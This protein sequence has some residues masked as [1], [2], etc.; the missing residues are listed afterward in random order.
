MSPSLATTTKKSTIP[1]I[2]DEK[3]II[4]MSTK[5]KQSRVILDDRKGFLDHFKPR[6][7]LFSVGTIFANFSQF[8]ALDM[9]IFFISFLEI[10]IRYV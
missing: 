2:E 1:G 9:L 5:V 6:P 8:V 4:P 7:L 10:N 3:F